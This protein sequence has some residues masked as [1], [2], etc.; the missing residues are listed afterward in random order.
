[1]GP[2][3]P[4]H[5]ITGSMKTADIM[6][7]SAR[8]RGVATLVGAVAVAV[9]GAV[10]LPFQQFGPLS[11]HMVLHI[12]LMNVVAP[13]VVVGLS[14]HLL[15]ALPR[16]SAVLLWSVTIGQ[17]ALL[18]ASHS[19][20]IHHAAQS[21]PPAL[22]TLHAALFVASLAFWICIIAASSPWQAMLALLISGKFACLLG[23]LL[24]FAPRLLFESSSLQHGAHAML[25]GDV[26]LSDQHLAGL[27]MVA[28]C[29]LSYVLTAI[30]LAAQTT[31]GLERS[32]SPAFSSGR[33]A[34]R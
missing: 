33:N 24:I 22:V 9:A 29:P 34:G 16:I 11:V 6:D 15:E 17:L 12:A 27:L 1:M 20:P 26:T 5:Q 31:S 14:G 2:R 4:R 10:L 3:Y 25:F 32:H 13:L 18:W 28:A 30:V 8:D 7:L 19:P 23:A 21:S